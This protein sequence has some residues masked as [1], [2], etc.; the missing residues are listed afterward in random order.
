MPMAPSSL[1][2]HASGVIGSDGGPARTFARRLRVARKFHATWKSDRRIRTFN[3]HEARMF[4]LNQYLIRY[5]R[6][7]QG[8]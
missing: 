2:E 3:F 1:P 5:L 4:R 7:I 6:E 8:R